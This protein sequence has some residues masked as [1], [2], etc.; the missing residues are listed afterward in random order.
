[1]GRE[2]PPQ[3]METAPLDHGTLR[4]L[5]ETGG[6]R[7][8]PQRLAVYD[9]LSL[10]HCHPTAE[11]I[12]QAVRTR[13]PQISLA[14]VYKA[15]E[16]LVAVGA[17]TKL[18]GGSATAGARY[19]ARRDRHYHFRCLRSGRVHDLPTQFDPDLSAKLDADLP[20]Y[21]K[22]QGFQIVGYSLVL[23]G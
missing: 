18:S 15:L 17:A 11:D 19:D 7:C 20:D 12:Y 8:T 16:A 2:R 3:D 13:I 6:L 4:L 22:R 10:A 23:L 1:M 14:T 5:L 9:Q 21:L